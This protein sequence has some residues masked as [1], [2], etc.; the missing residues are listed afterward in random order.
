MTATFDPAEVPLLTSFAEQATL[1]LE[2]GEK[3]R[4][5]RQLDV[6]ADRDRIARDLHDHVIQRLF[7]TGLQLQS[8]LRRIADPRCSER[9]QQAVEDLD[10]TIRE[11]RTSIFDLH[12]TGDAAGVQPAAAAARR[13]DRGRGGLGRRR[14]RCA[15]TGAVDTAGARRGRGARGRGGPRGGEQ[16]RAARPAD[17][18]HPHRRGAGDDLV[19]DVVDDG[20]GI[21]PGRG[22]RSGLRNLEQRAARVRR[23]ADRAR[24]GRAAARGWCGGS[25]P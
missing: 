10:A 7:A 14:R 9:I 12:T 22:A 15:S 23:R 19:I 18:G 24:P 6:F 16:R 4:A 11:I 20:V 8:T 13:R 5:Q 2:L 3:N 21:D 17:G 25:L 1:A